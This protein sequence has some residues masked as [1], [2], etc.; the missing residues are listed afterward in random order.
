MAWRALL[1][2]L[3]ESLPRKNAL[4]ASRPLLIPWHAGSAQCR[5]PL[6]RIV[7]TITLL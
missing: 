3:H 6:E 1:Q 2:H 4:A 5:F 7:D